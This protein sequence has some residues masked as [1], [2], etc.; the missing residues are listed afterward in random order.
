MAGYHLS[1]QQMQRTSSA[2]PTPTWAT[3]LSP[4]DVPPTDEIFMSK[5]ASPAVNSRPG[6]IYRAKD[7]GTNPASRSPQ[8]SWHFDYTSLPV[9]RHISC[10]IPR[11]IDLFQSGFRCV[12]LRPAH[13]KKSYIGNLR[14]CTAYEGMLTSSQLS[15]AHL[16]SAIIFSRRMRVPLRTEADSSNATAVGEPSWRNFLPLLSAPSPPPPSY[17]HLYP[18]H[19]ESSDMVTK[20]TTLHLCLYRVTTVP[21]PHPMQ[22]QL[23]RLEESSWRNYL[24]V[25]SAPSPPPPS[26]DRLLALNMEADAIEEAKHLQSQLD[27][28]EV[29]H[30]QLLRDEQDLEVRQKENAYER[31][32]RAIPISQQSFAPPMTSYM[33]CRRPP[34]VT[35]QSTLDALYDAQNAIMAAQYALIHPQSG[36]P[37][38]PY[39]M[40]HLLTISAHCSPSPRDRRRCYRCRQSYFLSNRSLGKDAHEVEDDQAK[41]KGATASIDDGLGDLAAL[42]QQRQNVRG[43]FFDPS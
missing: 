2:F 29:K 13:S 28:L 43:G 24:P 11:I 19:G 1:P 32:P 15:R 39:P 22:Y 23:S 35:V 20:I 36:V 40:A 26:Y 31:A 41:K 9:A 21:C 18:G 25:Q 6:K 10:L 30:S 38:Q 5:L 12:K 16:R 8:L 33:D 7:Y 27:A 4:P 14:I 3:S 42:I 17:D 34:A 37:Y